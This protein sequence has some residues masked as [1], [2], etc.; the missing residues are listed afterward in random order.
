M[1]TDDFRNEFGDG[2]DFLEEEDEFEETEEQSGNSSGPFLGM[3]PVQRFVLVFMLFMMICVISSFCLLV[4]NKIT[5]P[6]F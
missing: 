1:S 2:F 3:T 4:T 6:F 5:L